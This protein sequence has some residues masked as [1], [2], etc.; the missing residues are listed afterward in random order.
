M[1]GYVATIIA[2]IL[3]GAAFSGCVGT[4]QTPPAL[5]VDQIRYWWEGEL[6]IVNLTLTN[7]QNFTI[8]WDT[9]P[10]WITVEVYE[11]SWVPNLNGHGPGTTWTGKQTSSNCIEW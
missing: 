8:G 9:P 11:F 7:Q 4:L 10:P 5:R 3:L 1:G 6:L 2:A